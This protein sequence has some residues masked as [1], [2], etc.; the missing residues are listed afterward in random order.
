VVAREY[1]K[2]AAHGGGRRRR[3]RR[4]SRTGLQW[5]LGRIKGSSSTSKSRGSWCERWLGRRWS[6]VGCP[7]AGGARPE[8][9]QTTARKCRSVSENW[10]LGVAA[11]HVG[12]DVVL[13]RAR[14]RELRHCSE[15]STTAR[16]WRPEMARER[17]GVRGR[18]HQGREKG[19][20]SKGNDAW[21]SSAAGGG[22]RGAASAQSGKRRWSEEEEAERCQE[23]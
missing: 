6:G 17:R 14:E 3:R 23:D 7:R 19:S 5:K 16:R 20:G 1:L 2:R 12:V 11:Q 21:M 8:R 13:L 22:A 4:S 10:T 9:K 18:S 15:L